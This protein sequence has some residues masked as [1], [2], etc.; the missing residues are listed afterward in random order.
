[1]CLVASGLAPAAIG[2]KLEGEVEL[3]GLSAN[4]AR[5]YEVAQR[6][7]ILF[8]NPVTQLSTTAPTVYEEVAFGPRNLGLPIDEIIDRVECARS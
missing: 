2:G 5:P 1:M 8:Q 7:G 3:G 6:A 4:S